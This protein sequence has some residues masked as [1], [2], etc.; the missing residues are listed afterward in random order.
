MA[1]AR[2]PFST[3]GADLT[4][5]TFVGNDLAGERQIQSSTGI[6]NLLAVL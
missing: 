1:D 4:F 5:A 2:Y 6:N 3:S